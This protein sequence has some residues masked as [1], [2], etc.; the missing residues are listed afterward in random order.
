VS[1]P[2]IRDAEHSAEG[3]TDGAVHL[4]DLAAGHPPTVKWWTD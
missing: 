3:V 4:N 1:H 2:Q